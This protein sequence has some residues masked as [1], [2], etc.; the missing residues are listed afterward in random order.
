MAILKEQLAK[1]VIPPARYSALRALRRIQKI[2]CTLWTGCRVWCRF[3]IAKAV[4]CTFLERE[5][6]HSASSS[7]PRVCSST[8]TTACLWWILSTGACRCFTITDCRVRR[9]EQAG[10]EFG[11]ALRFAFRLGDRSPRADAARG[12]AG[13]S[14]PGTGEPRSGQRGIAGLP[15]L[16]RSSLWRKRAD[17]AEHAPVE[18]EALDRSE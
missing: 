2:T 4:C 11:Y 13:H 7:C 9:W 16:S 3:S 14:Q 10:E 1:L 15:V 5:V 18:P 17:H 6:R 8:A 12:C